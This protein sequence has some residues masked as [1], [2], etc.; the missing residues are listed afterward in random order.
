LKWHATRRRKQIPEL[1]KQK[2]GT[3]C[4]AGLDQLRN[5]KEREENL[6]RLS[7]MVLLLGERRI[8]EAIARPRK[9][10]HEDLKSLS[11][12][13]STLLMSLHLFSTVRGSLR[14]GVQTSMLNEMI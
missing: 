5:L 14:N 6:L 3:I 7:T 11:R 10:R 1:I 9:R 8:Q 13:S 4:A 2:R 12:L